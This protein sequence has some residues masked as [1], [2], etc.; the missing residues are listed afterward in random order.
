[1]WHNGWELRND[2]HVRKLK[3]A[4]SKAKTFDEAESFWGTCLE[5]GMD[6]MRTESF[7]NRSNKENKNP[8]CFFPIFWKVIL[9]V[10]GETVISLCRCPRVN[11]LLLLTP[12][13][14]LERSTLNDM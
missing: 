12:H 11:Y 3:Q 6:V 2:S 4:E 14:I 9:W 10:H 1:M 8:R 5:F 13:K 7:L